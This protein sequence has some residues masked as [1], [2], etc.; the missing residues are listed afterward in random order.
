LTGLTHPTADNHKDIYK[1]DGSGKWL[2]V[3]GT[4]AC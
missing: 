1:A 2:F 3:G 4:H